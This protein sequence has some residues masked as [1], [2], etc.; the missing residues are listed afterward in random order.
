M[1]GQKTVYVVLT[2]IRI[3]TQ[4]YI[5]RNSTALPDSFKKTNDPGVPGYT[6]KRK[7]ILIVIKTHKIICV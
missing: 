6:L 1:A 5:R 4:G 3:N 2:T 7:N